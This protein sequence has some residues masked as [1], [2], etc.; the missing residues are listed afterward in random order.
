[1]RKSADTP[2]EQTIP[3]PRESTETTEP[4]L[5]PPPAWPEFLQTATDNEVRERFS[6]ELITIVGDPGSSLSGYSLLALL[7][8]EDSIGPFELDQIYRA[9]SAND[10]RDRNVL[11][12]RGGI[13]EPAYQ[14]S[15]LC[16]A[17]SK[18][19]FV[20]V[21][22]RQAKSAATPIALG[23]DEIHPFCP[24]LKNCLRARWAGQ[25]FFGSLV[26]SG[27]SEVAGH[28]SNR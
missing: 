22:P 12:S 3:E 2:P 11:L 17:Y 9:L 7:E 15:K 10:S 20:V 8:P 1:L 27:I 16:K 25:G 19:R 6:W 24:H 23:A 14:I 18:E 4:P 28:K 5:S 26:N 13:I 21:I